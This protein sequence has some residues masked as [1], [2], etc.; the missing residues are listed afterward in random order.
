MLHYLLLLAE[1]LPLA[2]GL[3]GQPHQV[4]QTTPLRRGKES[5][6]R[7]GEFFVEQVAD[8]LHHLLHEQVGRDCGI[9]S[10]LPW[11]ELIYFRKSIGSRVDA[12]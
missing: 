12:G 5:G 3:D 11:P 9:V 10:S 6:C 7:E 4:G 1:H 2:K 8:A